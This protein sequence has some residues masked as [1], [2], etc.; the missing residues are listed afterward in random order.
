MR[1]VMRPVRR[2]LHNFDWQG[3]DGPCVQK[4]KEKNLNGLGVHG[5]RRL[6]LVSRPI[7]AGAVF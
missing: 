2:S 1:V 7:A 6:G 4:E 5:R 3:V